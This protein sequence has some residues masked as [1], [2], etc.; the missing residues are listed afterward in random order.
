MTTTPALTPAPLRQLRDRLDGQLILPGTPG[1][2]ESRTVWNAMIDR[3]PRAVVRTAS[4]R[5]VAAAVRTARELDL[6]IGV[7]G[8]GHG[9]LGHA[10]PDDG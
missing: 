2:D 9:V 10:G 1:Y 7:R 8:G 3:R 5:D 4:V 6:P